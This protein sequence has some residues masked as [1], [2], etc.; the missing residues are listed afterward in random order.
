MIL[1][2]TTIWSLALRRKAGSLSSRESALV[3]EWSRLATAG[4]AC[5]TGPI[6]QEILSGIRDAAVFKAIQQ[7]LRDFP[8]VVVIDGDHDRAAEFYNTCRSHGVAGTAVDML[9][10]A[11]AARSDTPIFTT[12][13]DFAR[14]AKYLPLRLHDLSA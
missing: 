1:V 2:D 8:H 10:C 11:V 5:L 7:I 9:I 13:G 14:Y 6:R 3:E 12:D 4:Q